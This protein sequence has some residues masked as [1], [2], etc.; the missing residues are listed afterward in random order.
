MGSL[1]FIW[2]LVALLGH[3]LIGALI[4]LVLMIL[5]RLGLS[6]PALPP[7]VQWWHRRAVRLLGLRLQVSGEPLPGA[8]LLVANHI[9][10]LDIPAL[11][12]VRQMA[13]LSKSEVRR[14]PLVGW[15]AEFA[16]TLFIERGSNQSEQVRDAIRGRLEQGGQ[17]VFFPEGTTTDGSDVRRFHP[18]LFAAAQ[19]SV[20][21]LQPVSLRYL[22][23]PGRASVAPFIGDDELMPHLLR[24]L[25]EPW[26][27]VEIRFLPALDAGEMDRKSLAERTRSSIRESLG[28]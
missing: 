10:W 28:L 17:V 9:S 19:Q 7:I 3:V 27:T 13:F 4:T 2:R 26:I 22:P 23:A 11:G 15:M 6:W 5:R 8:A 25:K 12:A 24:V 14:W 16:G 1:R 21:P 20:A 18:R